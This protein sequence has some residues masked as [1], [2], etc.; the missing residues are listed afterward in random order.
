[1]NRAQIR[2][3]AFFPVLFILQL[4]LLCAIAAAQST[5]KGDKPEGAGGP[6][7]N[8]TDWD[9]DPSRIFTAKE[10]TKKAVLLS[11]PQPGFTKEAQEN[12]VEGVVRLRMVLSSDGSVKN[13]SVVKGLPDGLTEKA[14]AAARG[15]KFVP[16]EKDGRR[17]S[18]WVTIEYNYNIYFDEDDVALTRKL[19]ILEKPEPQYT[20]EA[21]RNRT[22]GTVVLQLALYKDGGI[23]VTVV[24]GLPDGLTEKAI[25]AARAIKFRP[26]E[27]NGRPVNIVRTIEYVFSLD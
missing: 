24:K 17:V 4:A 1:M 9:S 15:I 8:A 11:K 6:R 23:G 3:T 5:D 19:S 20:E 14:I 13:I 2:K 21:R 7:T 26:G 10:V 18:Q 25:E 16:A 12:E 27:V 22:Q